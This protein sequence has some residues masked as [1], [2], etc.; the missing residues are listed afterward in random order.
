M[1]TTVIKSPKFKMEIGEFDSRTDTRSHSSM[2]S[3]QQPSK[4]WV[5]GSNPSGITKKRDNQSLFFSCTISF[6]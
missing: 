1:D 2:E 6:K 4:L 3:E 5:E